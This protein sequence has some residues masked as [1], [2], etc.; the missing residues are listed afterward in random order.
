M[1]A[2]DLPSLQPI[3]LTWKA[4]RQELG[5]RQIDVGTL[6]GFGKSAQSNMSNREQPPEHP[7]STEPSHDELVRFEDHYGLQRGTVLRRA[8]YV[9]DSMDPLETVDSWSFLDP[10]EKRIIRGVVQEALDRA[11]RPGARSRETA[12]S[13]SGG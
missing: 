6:L 11:G 8:G 1:G 7:A 2:A 9:V 12:R 10:T 5:V 3:G 13:P 4:I